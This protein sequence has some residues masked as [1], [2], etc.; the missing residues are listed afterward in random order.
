MDTKILIFLLFLILI[1]VIVGSQKTG[2]FDK[3]SEEM[4]ET[5]SKNPFYTDPNFH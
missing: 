1:L 5:F 3:Q 2:G 4:F